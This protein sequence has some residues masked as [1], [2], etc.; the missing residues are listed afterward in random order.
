MLNVNVDRVSGRGLKVDTPYPEFV[1]Y[2]GP[3]GD[4]P[5]LLKAK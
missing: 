3:I 4:M 2:I 5:R 1:C